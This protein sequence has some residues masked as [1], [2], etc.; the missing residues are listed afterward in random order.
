M[1]LMRILGFILFI[2]FALTLLAGCFAGKKAFTSAQKFRD[3]SGFELP[4]QIYFPKSGE[5]TM[6]PVFIWLH[7]MG[8]RGDDNIKQLV[9]VVPY[10][11]S[12]TVQNNYPCIVAAPQCPEDGLWAFFDF[13]AGKSDKTPVA[14][15]P[16]LAVMEWIDE[17]LK[18][19]KV[20]RTRVYVGGLSMGGYGTLD[21]ISR[22]PEWFAAA[23]PVCGGIDVA[24]AASF[25]DVPLWIFHGAKDPVVPV[26]LSRDLIKELENLGV[27]PKYTEY[28]KGGHDVWNAAIREQGFMKWLFDQTL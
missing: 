8:E 14:T 2:G 15:K 4:Y 20:D 12:D 19:P 25:R 18:D 7:G 9:H 26:E 27:K 28:P 3:S 16:M 10:L 22:K 23:M 6:F 1:S 24:R 11:L 13:E 17:L 21:L 5:K